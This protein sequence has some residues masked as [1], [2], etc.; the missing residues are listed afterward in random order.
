MKIVFLTLYILYILIE[1]LE[2]YYKRRT[3]KI[4]IEDLSEDVIR[5]CQIMYPVRKKSPCVLI[6]DEKSRSAGEYCYLTNTI[7]IYRRNNLSH[8]F[9]ISTLIHEYFHY[10]LITSNDKNNLYQKQLELY[11]YENHPQEII[12]RAAADK[13]EKEYLNSRF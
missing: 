4:P 10:Y 6:S 2:L 13:L 3:Q 1:L 8:N 5:W 12:C 11:G 9:L 7:K